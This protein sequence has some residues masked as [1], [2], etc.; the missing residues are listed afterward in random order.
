M[1]ADTVSKARRSWIM[2]RVRSENTG[3]E[4]VV[5]S[6]AH[7]LGFRFALHRRDLPGSPDIVFPCRHRVIFVHGCFWHGHACARGNR[8]PVTHAAYWRTKIKKNRRRDARNNS[9]L[10]KL[11]WKVLSVWECQ[12]ADEKRVAVRVG[13][14]LKGSAQARRVG[15]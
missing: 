5:R 1:M 15:N 4:R 7:R 6:L 14:F 8:L 2:S 3:P 12:I 13:E 11:G 9:R 10:R